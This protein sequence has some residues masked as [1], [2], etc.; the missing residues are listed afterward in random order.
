MQQVLNAKERTMAFWKFILFFVVAVVSILLAVFFNTQVPQKENTRLK[1][2][3]NTYAAHISMEQKFTSAMQEA[4]SYLDSL[5]KP[6]TNVAYVNQ[7]VSNKIS[8]MNALQTQGK[9]DGSAGS[10]NA[11]LLDV[12]FKYQQAKMKLVSLNDAATQLEKAKADLNQCNAELNQARQ[13]IR[14]YQ[15]TNGGY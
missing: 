10:E 15:N 12:M 5:D 9:Q 7:L 4:V 2:K 1:E 6:G 14:L 11:V 3:T 8:E 13:T